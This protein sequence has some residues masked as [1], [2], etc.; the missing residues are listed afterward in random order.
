MQIMKSIVVIIA[1]ILATGAATLGV[2]AFTYNYKRDH[3]NQERIAKAYIDYFRVQKS[4]P[5][6]LSDLVGKGYLPERSKFYQDIPSFFNRETSYRQSSY[7]V[8]APEDGKIE[9]LRMIARK[10]TRN[11]KN[12][13][14]FNPVVNATMRDEIKELGRSQR[15]Q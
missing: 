11:G 14:E 13:W 8:F 1:V 5:T 4:F 15:P 7:E 3:A 10:V 9:D 6:A 12:E 2:Y